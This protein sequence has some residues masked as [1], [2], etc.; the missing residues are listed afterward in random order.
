MV[1]RGACICNNCLST[2]RLGGKGVLQTLDMSS[3][4]CLTWALVP[5]RE[6]CQPTSV[7]Q[8]NVSFSYF[9]SNRR[10][11]QWRRASGTFP[12]P[13]LHRP[14]GAD[15]RRVLRGLGGIFMLFLPWNLSPSL[16]PPQ[17]GCGQTWQQLHALSPPPEKEMD[18]S[19]GRSGLVYL[20]RHT[21]CLLLH[22]C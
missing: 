18:R 9:V 8:L 6:E 12:R 15:F 17:K 13:L 14:A 10:R 7:F 4:K 3:R 16:P 19:D 20:P 22:L 21:Q 11:L 1:A 2:K 5:A